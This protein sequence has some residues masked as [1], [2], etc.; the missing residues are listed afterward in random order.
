MKL[1]RLVLAIA[2][3]VAFASPS[4]AQQRPADAAPDSA[5]AYR[6]QVVI[7]EYD[8]ATKISSLPYSVPVSVSGDPRAQGSLRVGIRVPINA[9]TKSGESAVQYMDIGTNLDIR[10]KHVDT[11]RFELELTIERSSLYVREENKEGKVEGRAWAPG[12]PVPGLAPVNQQLRFNE[13][14]LLRDGR[15][16]ETASI[17]DPV[18][19]HVLKVDA[20]LTVLK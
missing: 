12:D 18:T 9:S 20:V 10:V 3:A 2:A 14:L 7:A 5:I 4:R 8:G 15:P 6:V 11:E 16:G 17:T 19:G 1:T 13:K